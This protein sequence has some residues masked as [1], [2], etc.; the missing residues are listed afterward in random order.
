MTELE[1]RRR[2]SIHDV[3]VE[4]IDDG[5]QVDVDP[6]VDNAINGDLH[7]LCFDL[8][9]LAIAASPLQA[10]LQKTV[11]IISAIDQSHR[12]FCSE[13]LSLRACTEG[14]D[15]QDRCAPRCRGEAAIANG[16]NK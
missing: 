11:I 5:H 3:N 8:Q 15:D 16:C 13:H 6:D 9:S 10:A 1:L 4:R 14:V 12:L 2:G 7:I